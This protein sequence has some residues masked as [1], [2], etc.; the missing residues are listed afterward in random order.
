MSY[1]PLRPHMTRRQWVSLLSIGCVS[2][3]LSLVFWTVKS[4]GSIPFL[5]SRSDLPVIRIGTL[6]RAIDYAPYYV[7]K[8]KG[9]FEDALKG[10]A[11]VEH[12][13]TFQSPPSASEALG[14]DRV[15][16]LMTADVPI[17]VTRATGVKVRVPMLSCTL[18][19]QIVVKKTSTHRRLS[20]LIGK[21]VAVAFGTGPHYGL[22]RNLQVASI[23]KSKVELLN[24]IPPDA[25]AAFSANVIDAW[26]IFP[27]Y[28]EQEILNGNGIALEDVTS[29][30]QVVVSVRE[31]SMDTHRELIRRVLEQLQRARTWIK[32]NPAEAQDLMARLLDRMC[33]EAG[34]AQGELQPC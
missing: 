15:D 29:P 16:V 33:S 18:H 13:P 26:A 1:H 21:R 23:D 7:A 2:L 19:S 24:M 11:T 8:D 34:T 12:L 6:F 4:T 25:K 30:V 17:I 22:L 9:W 10:E 3:I 31:Q 14:A 27:P 20:D 32:A 28:I 5:G